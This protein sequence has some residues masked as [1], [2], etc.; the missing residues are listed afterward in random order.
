MISW[1][2]CGVVLSRDLLDD[3]SLE[4]HLRVNRHVSRYS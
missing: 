1:L 2:S 3:M 4:F